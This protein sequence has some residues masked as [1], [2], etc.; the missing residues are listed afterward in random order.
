MAPA[1][2]VATNPSK[3]LFR[4][5]IDTVWVKFYGC[6]LPLTQGDGLYTNTPLRL[7]DPDGDLVYTGSINLIPPA[8]YDAGF[9][10]N[11]SSEAGAVIQNGGGFTKGR[12]YYQY[13]HPTAVHANGSVDWPEEYVLPVLDWMNSDLTVEDPPD[14]WTPTG[15]NSGQGTSAAMNFELRQNYP[16]P[17]NPETAI[18]YRIAKTSRVEIGI[19]NLK[20]QLIRILVQGKQNPGAYSVRW[21]GLSQDGGLMPSGMYLVKMKTESFSKTRKLTLLR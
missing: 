5:G 8:P 16:N 14:L 11:Y 15:V 19:Y 12:N 13:V 17:F 2:D 18:D 7:E 6:V 20:G 1:T 4:P 3:P 21:N 10:V 9:R